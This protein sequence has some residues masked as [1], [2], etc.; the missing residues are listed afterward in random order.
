MSHSEMSATEAL[1]EAMRKP[2]S[3]GFGLGRM[4]FALV[5][6]QIFAGSVSD[7]A[8]GLWATLW[9]VSFGQYATCRC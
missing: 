2:L 8:F 1:N 3:P 9:G 6:Y 5:T 4:L 7:T